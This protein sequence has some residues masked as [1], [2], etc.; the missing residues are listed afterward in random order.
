[1]PSLNGLNLTSISMDIAP[2]IIET[3]LE[4]T[5]TEKGYTNLKP[6]GKISNFPCVSSLVWPGKEIPTVP[7]R[8]SASH[9]RLP[10]GI[11]GYFVRRPTIQLHHLCIRF[12]M[13]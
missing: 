10:Y 2:S 12:E 11:E 13:N 3:W 6:M 5:V 8:K 9:L 4:S 7:Q 1:M